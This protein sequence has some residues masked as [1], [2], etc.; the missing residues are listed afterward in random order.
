V[1]PKVV[2]QLVEELKGV[3][4]VGEICPHVGVGCLSY[5]GMVF[6]F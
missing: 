3:M 5:L 6:S 4:Q 2:I 1:A